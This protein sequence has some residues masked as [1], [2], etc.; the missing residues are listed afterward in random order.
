MIL[1]NDI[2]LN[3]NYWICQK[4]VLG[5]TVHLPVSAG[6][7]LVAIGMTLWAGSWK[8]EK[9]INLSWNSHIHSFFNVFY[10]NW[11]KWV[12]LFKNICLLMITVYCILRSL[13]QSAFLFFLVCTLLNFGIGLQVLSIIMYY[14]IF[15]LNT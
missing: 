10:F 8:L 1:C 5:V 14:I 3:V 9:N 4:K 13:C 11:L 2:W 6:V 15:F 12:V 7:M